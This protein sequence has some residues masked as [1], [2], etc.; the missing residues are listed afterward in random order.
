[1]QPSF[2]SVV[3]FELSGWLLAALM[4]N[5]QA[6]CSKLLCLQDSGGDCFKAKPAF[7]VCTC[8]FLKHKKSV[9]GHGGKGC[10][11]DV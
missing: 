4:A 9:A 5:A 3:F 11:S 6:W 2:H 7:Y 8:K 10:G 1:M